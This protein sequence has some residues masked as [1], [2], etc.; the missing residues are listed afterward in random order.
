VQGFLDV[1]GAWDATLAFVMGSALATTALGYRIVRAQGRPVLAPSFALPTRTDL[2]APLVVGAAL[3][4]VGWGLV[5][6]CPGP[7]IASLARGSAELL[8]FVAALVAGAA[9]Q[10]WLRREDG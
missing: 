1:A 2:D 3:F 7:A 6:L 8:V 9:A 10:R 4:G 5:G